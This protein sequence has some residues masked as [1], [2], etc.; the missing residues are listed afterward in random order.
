MTW[1]VC[2]VR[3]LQLWINT[4]HRVADCFLSLVW[5]TTE[6]SV[7]LQLSQTT[8]IIEESPTDQVKTT[9]ILATELLRTL[10]IGNLLEELILAIEV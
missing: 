5:R 2:I 1:Y 10:Y 7:L 4:Y 8:L 6:G 3:A 9:T